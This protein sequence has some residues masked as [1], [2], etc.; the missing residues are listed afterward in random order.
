M[1]TEALLGQGL[2]AV[3]VVGGMLAWASE[4]LPVVAGDGLPGT[5]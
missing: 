4:D 1:A 5:I 3:N 2:D